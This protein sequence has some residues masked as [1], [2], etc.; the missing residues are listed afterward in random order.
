[1]KLGAFISIKDL[2]YIEMMKKCG[3]DYV[4]A[5]INQLNK[6]T[7]EELCAFEEELKKYNYKCEAVN[8]LFPGDVIVAGPDADL[9]KVEDYLAKIFEKTKR[10]GYKAVVFGS[11]A[12]R[13]LPDDFPYE[14]ATEQ[15]CRICSDY[16]SPMG[17]KYGFRVA[18]EELNGGETNFINYV[19]EAYEIAKMVN[20]PEIGIVCD[21]FH[22]ALSG[23]PYSLLEKMGDKIVHAHT[24]NPVKRQYPKK[25]D[26]HRYDLFIGAMK[27]GGYDERVTVESFDFASLPEGLPNTAEAFKDL[28]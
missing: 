8:C 3:Y 7:E 27:K 14:K 11:G 21:S 24:A 13:V 2:H 26:G 20:K 17:K 23:E 22:I 4:E 25:G 28:L 1:M 5:S 10:F 9:P 12:S 15:F 18:I 6:S 19:S 16:L